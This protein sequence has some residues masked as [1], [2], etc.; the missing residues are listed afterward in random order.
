[1]SIESTIRQHVQE[2]YRD[3]KTQQEV[4]DKLNISRSYIQSLMTGRRR[5]GGSTV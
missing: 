3:G 5:Y 2:L 4:G 1:M